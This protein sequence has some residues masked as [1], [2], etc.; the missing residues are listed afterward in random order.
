MV[1]KLGLKLVRHPHPYHVQWLNDSG[2][3]KIAYPFKIWE[4]I[5]TVECDVAPMSVCHLLLG[6]SWQYDRYSQYCRRTNHI[7]LDLKGKKFVLKPVTPQQ[8]MAEHLQKKS[9]NVSV[10]GEKG[11]QKK[12]SAIHNSVSECHKPNLREKNKGEGE[13]LIMLAIKFKMR[14]VRNNP[15]QVLFVLVYTD[16]LVSAND[17]TSFPS[18]VSHLLEDYEDVF[19][20]ETPAG[21]PPICGIEDQ[22]VLIPGAALPNRPPYRTNLEEQRRY[23]GKCKNFLIKVLFM[24]V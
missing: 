1:D 12:L 2:D 9:E 11:E 3:I 18:V 6:R 7:T 23:K 24:K 16:I 20:K 10:S 15:D 22:I 8:I 19:P 13:H 14:E 5:D 17:I 4:Y 21:L